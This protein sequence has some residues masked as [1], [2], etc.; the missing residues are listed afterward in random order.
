MAGVVAAAAQQESPVGEGGGGG[1]HL[2]PQVVLSVLTQLQ[3][4]REQH[5]D[6]FLFETYA[7]FSS[8]QDW[9]F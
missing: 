2:E 9:A 8:T 4:W 3:L 6:L 7:F 5:E 1:V